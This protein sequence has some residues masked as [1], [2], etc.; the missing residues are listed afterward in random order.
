MAIYS[1][2]PGPLKDLIMTL[3]FNWRAAPTVGLKALKR[4]ESRFHWFAEAKNQNPGLGTL[5]YLPIE[6][7]HLI[8]KEII[9]AVVE[10]F[11]GYWCFDRVSDMHDILFLPLNARK[12]GPLESRRT[13][14]DIHALRAA[15]GIIQSE[16]HQMHLSQTVM[17]LYS[18]FDHQFRS[19]STQQTALISRMAM[20]LHPRYNGALWIRFLRQNPLPNLQTVALGL[21]HDHGQVSY[22]KRLSDLATF[23]YCSGEQC[24]SGFDKPNADGRRCNH[25]NKLFRLAKRLR[26]DLT[27]YEVISKIL[28]KNVPNAYIQQAR[29]PEHCSMCYKHCGAILQ[30]VKSYKDE[31]LVPTLDT[32]FKWQGLEKI[33]PLISDGHYI[34]SSPEAMRREHLKY[35]EA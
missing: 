35:F 5:G 32:T 1:A 7:R 24:K 21:G 34:V 25:V 14:Q 15:S 9:E 13:G 29:R 23:Q 4:S 8:Y 26:Q 28:T 19:L 20:D 12:K 10:D 33:I 31:W 27:V 16:I 30:H 6:V 2:S 17:K 18:P 22:L 3:P 11:K